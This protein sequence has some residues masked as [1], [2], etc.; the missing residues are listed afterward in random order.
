MGR[1]NLETLEIIPDPVSLIESMRSVGYTA[2][3]AIA[4]LIDNSI[5]AE[6]QSVEI[7]YDA[8]GDPYVAMLDDGRGMNPAELTQA[9]RHGSRNPAD[10]R[11]ANDLGRFGLGLKTAS[12]SQ[13][14][15]LTVVSKQAGVLA[16]RCWDLDVVQDS[17][18]WLVVVP[19]HEVIQKLPMSKRLDA[20]DSGTLVVWQDFDRLSAGSINLAREFTTKFSGLREHLAL[21]FHRFTSKENGFAPVSIRLNGLAL[22]VRDPFIHSN[23]YR[24]PMEG[25]TIRHERGLVR[26]TPH[27]LPPVSHLS[28]DD[29]ETAGGLEGLR[30]T[31]GFYVYRNRRLVIWGTWFRLVPKQEFFKLTRVQV[32]IPNTFD[33]LW[34][35]DIKKSAAQPPEIIRNRLTELIPHFAEASKKTVTYPGRRTGSTAYI[36]VWARYEQSHGR[37]R[38][39]VNKDHPAIIALTSDMDEGKRRQLDVILELISSA[40]PLDGIYADMCSDR[41]SGGDDQVFDSLARMA[42]SLKEATGMALSVILDTDPFIRYPGLR[43]RIIQRDK[44]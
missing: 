43:D 12:L 9:M 4:D 13:C 28:P 2:E 22:P 44:I 15:V 1:T 14:R 11:H 6:A 24:Q 39:D 3:S 26:V 32:D 18:R 20:M 17:G 33:E 36:P 27:V 31:Q 21:V 42:S 29:I 23:S 30:G 7:E 5:S 40:I 35:L 25:Q 41:R 16:A 19:S 34:S 38:Y 8:T 37:F 10:H